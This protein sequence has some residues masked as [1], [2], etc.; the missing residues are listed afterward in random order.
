[1]IVLDN[2]APTFSTFTTQNIFESQ[3]WKYQIIATDPESFRLK[4]TLV[5]ESYGIRISPAG[6]ITW[7]PKERKVYSF[8]VKA[9]DPCGLYTT[10]KF[11]VEVQ[12]CT[13]KER[14]GA[15]CKWNNTVQPEKEVTC[16]CPDGCVGERFEI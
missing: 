12:N 3:E 5:G 7:I 15:I 1:M 10:K 8:T 13:C 2:Q 4:Y 6:M 11:E 16:V 14:N 9:E